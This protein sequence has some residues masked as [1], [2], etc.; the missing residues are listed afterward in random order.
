VRTIRRFLARIRNFSTNRR[1]HERLR[2]EIEAHIA[3]QTEEFVRAGVSPE[4]AHRQARLKFGAVEAVREQYHAE[5]GLPFAENVLQDTR[6]ALRQL[7]KSPGFTFIAVL[8]L[9]LGI[10]A[11]TAIFT[12]VNAVLLSKLPVAYPKM[13]VR[14]GDQNDCCI[15]YGVHDNGDYSVFST[16]AWEQLR[17]N[18]PEFEELAAMQSGFESQPI[19]VR[20]GG[21]Q[22]SA[23]S[24]IGEFVS[25]NYFSMF[26]L[27]PAIGRLFSD[28]DDNEGASPTA[29]MSYEAWKDS[30]AA[31]PAIVG[32]KFMLTPGP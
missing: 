24:A 28:A 5:E 11:N 27:S 22:T 15:G 3:A 1:D 25:G 32:S 14:L 19:I 8:T 13:L 30:Y 9:A 18:A 12:L 26:G 10:G 20:H 2:E 4:E 23:H 6:F 16:T 29:V 31:D 7:G 21:A 17:K